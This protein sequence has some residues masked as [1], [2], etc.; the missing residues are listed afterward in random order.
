MNGLT[1]LS[2]WESMLTPSTVGNSEVNDL[3][4]PSLRFPHDEI[5]FFHNGK[6][7]GSLV[8]LLPEAT[9]ARYLVTCIS[10]RG[11]HHDPHERIEYIGE[12]GKWRL[13]ESAAIHRIEEGRDSFFIH[14]GQQSLD[15][16]VATQKGRKYLKTKPDN[17]VSSNLLA[18]PEC[19]RCK[20]LA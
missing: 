6:L 16:V 14:V 17:Y 18:L 4:P 2:A 1:S 8:Y 10:K 7:Q 9:M 20:Q 11:N 12:Q 19:A 15:I 13:S 3:D 5:L